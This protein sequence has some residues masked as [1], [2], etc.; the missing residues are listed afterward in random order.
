MYIGEL[1]ANS[2]LF[3]LTLGVVEKVIDSAKDWEEKDNLLKYL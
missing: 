2:I 3:Q 1:N